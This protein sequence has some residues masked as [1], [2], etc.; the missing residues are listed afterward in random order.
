VPAPAIPDAQMQQFRAQ[1]EP[2]LKVELSF[3]NRVC[4]PS[5]AERQAL[6]AKSNTWLETLIREYAKKGGQPNVEGAWFGGRM[7]NAPNPREMLEEGIKKVVEESLSEDQVKLFSDE[8]SKRKEFEKQTALDNLISKIDGELMLTPEQRDKLTESL[9]DHW[10]NSWAPQLEYFTFGVD[11]LPSVPDQ[12]IRPHL[13]AA[14][15]VVWSRLNKQSGQMFFGGNFFGMQGNVIEDIDLNE[16]QEKQPDSG[17][18]PNE[19]KSRQP[20]VTNLGVRAEDQ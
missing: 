9:G 12:W 7:A 19:D 8:S 17:D 6:I 13:T 20:A 16:G 11:M 4:K 1:F 10:Q 18:D 3:I 2:M 14:Q 15:L 5:D